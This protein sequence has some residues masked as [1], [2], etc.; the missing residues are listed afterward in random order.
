MDMTALKVAE[1]K[2]LKQYPAGFNH[3]EMI[4]IGK[5]HKMEQLEAFAKKSFAK[6]NFD[7]PSLIVEEVGRLV[8]RSTMISMFDKPK[9][10]DYI[11]AFRSKDKEQFSQ[12]IYELLHGAEKKG[13]DSLVDQLKQKK[14]GKWPLTTVIQA[15]YRPQKEVFIKS[16]T[17]KLIIE[18]LGLDLEYKPTPTWDFYRK[19]RQSINVLK[20]NSNKNLAPNN[21][22]FCGF[23]MMT[24]GD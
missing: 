12:I 8:A 10:R 24:L 14:L 13:F 11:K 17:V 23:L 9:F 5:K 4:K 1:K 21:P 15:Y 2:F 20:A 3:P 22:A 7:D 16:T 18:K 19:F 6:K